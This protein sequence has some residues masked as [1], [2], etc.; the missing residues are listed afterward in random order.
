MLRKSFVILLIGVLLSSLLLSACG[1]KKEEGKKSE[2]KEKTPIGVQLSWIDTIEFI[3]FY[4]ADAQGYYDEAGLEVTTHRGGFDE[5]GNY[6]DPITRVLNGEVQF[7]VKAAADIL[8]ARAEGKPVVAIASIYQRSPA[9]IVS[10][11]ASNITQPADLK[12]KRVMVEFGTNLTALYLAFLASEGIERSDI[13]EV[14]N[15]GH[16]VDPLLNGEVDA[17]LGFITN[18]SLQVR[19]RAEGE[20]NDLFL[21]DYGVDTY[22]NTIFTTEDMIKNKPDLVEAFLRA[23]LRGA[24][25][26]VANPDQAAELV[27]QRFGDQL[28][29]TV[30]ELQREAMQASLPLL[31]PAG[32]KIGMMQPEVWDFTQQML[33]DQGTLSEPVEVEKAYTLEFLNKIYQQ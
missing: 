29:D 16:V 14:I 2:S 12:G 31:N 33:L 11:G 22:V 5:Q 7:G 10:L 6:I 18:E 21:S 23:T 4:A 30:K 8:A 25:W 17:Y 20:V 9:S 1:D 15:E 32:S 28:P 3:D 13:V 26:A 27:V 24:E 19:H